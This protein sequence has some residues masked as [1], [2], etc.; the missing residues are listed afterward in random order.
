MIATGVSVRAPVPVALAGVL[1]GD[2]G[3]FSSVPLCFP[4]LAPTYAAKADT[5]STLFVLAA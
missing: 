5:S 3:R 4:D 1:G 2:S